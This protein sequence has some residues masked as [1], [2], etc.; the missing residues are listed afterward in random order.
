MSE[1]IVKDLMEQTDICKRAAAPT[2]ESTHFNSVYGLVMEDEVEEIDAELCNTQLTIGEDEGGDSINDVARTAVDKQHTH[3]LQQIKLQKARKSASKVVKK[4]KLTVG[5]HHG[6]LNPL[7]SNWK[8]TSMPV[9]MLIQNWFIGDL[10]RNIPPLHTLDSKH[11]QY[12][13]KGKGNKV[14][15]KMKAFMKIV[16]AEAKAK[17]VWMEKMSDWDY[18][19]VTRMWDA[20]KEDFNAKYCKTSRK[21]ELSWSTVYDNMS[22]ANAFNNKR[23][24]AYRM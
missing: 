8:F 10:N 7:P 23:N 22:K 12:L 13:L 1:K 9:L 17:D 21:K 19:T 24:K 2:I 18:T 14:R 6:T 5:Y 16:E 3:E 15:T 4:R 20:I 11:V